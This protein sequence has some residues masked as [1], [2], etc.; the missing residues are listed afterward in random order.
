MF[1]ATHGKPSQGCSLQLGSCALH[2]LKGCYICSVEGP[3]ELGSVVA[4]CLLTST[5]VSMPL[6]SGWKKELEVSNFFFLAKGLLPVSEVWLL[7]PEA[8]F[9]VKRT[10]GLGRCV[11]M[12][13]HLCVLSGGVFVYP[14]LGFSDA[15]WVCKHGTFSSVDL[16]N[17]ANAG[18][19]DCSNLHPS[20]PFGKEEHRKENK[21]DC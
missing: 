5:P 11:C 10:D 6:L 9:T 14:I 18:K 20:T 17:I 2:N 7:T 1:I 21:A 8:Q 3:L 19:C 4:L 16:S 12:Y 13:V 15:V